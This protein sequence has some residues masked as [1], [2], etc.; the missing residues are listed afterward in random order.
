MPVLTS[1][2]SGLAVMNTRILLKATSLENCQGNTNLQSGE[3]TDVTNYRPISVLPIL[4]KIAERHVHNAVY[5][6]LCENDLICIRQSGFRSKHST[7]T[8]LIKIIDDLIFNLDNDRVSGMVLVDYLKAF[9][10]I[11]HT[12]LLKKLEVYGLNRDSLQW[13]ISY[14]KEIKDAIW[15]SWE[16]NSQVSLLFVMVFPRDPYLAPSYLS[17][18]SMTYRFTSFHQ[19]LICMPTIQR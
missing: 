10:M 3:P 1:S 16:I 15:L 6:F 12:L 8:A 5:S 17:P 9:D 4:S 7:E 18:L 14:L 13:F 19:Q 2:A 11:D